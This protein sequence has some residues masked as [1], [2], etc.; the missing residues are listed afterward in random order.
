VGWVSFTKKKDDE[1]AYER[2][3][4]PKKNDETNSFYAITIRKNFRRTPEELEE[5]K[6][7]KKKIYDFY[8]MDV[9]IDNYCS[10]FLFFH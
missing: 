5:A 2:T 7:R 3:S 10:F 4:G 8:Q 9:R 6:K 1:D